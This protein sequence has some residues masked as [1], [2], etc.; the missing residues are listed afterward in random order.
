MIVRSAILFCL[1]T[2]LMPSP[3]PA[4]SSI[5]FDLPTSAAAIDVTPDDMTGGEKLVAIEF[6]LSLIADSLPS[7]QAEQLVVQ[8]SPLGGRAVIADY[9]PRTELGSAV[10]GEIEISRTKEVVDNLGL[11]LDASYGHLAH[12]NLGVDRGEKNI[13]ATK[14][15]EVAPL[16]IVAASGTT[17]R[18]RGVYFKL[19][20]D[21]RQVLEG[22][23]TF[24]VVLRV[25]ASW[26]GELM[27]VRVEAESL[28][29]GFSALA[30]MAPKSRQVG[31]ARFL[32]ATFLTGDRQVHA[33]AKHVGDA[34]LAMRESATRSLQGRSTSPLSHVAFRFDIGMSSGG[35]DLQRVT[36]TIERVLFAS[37][38]PYV[39]PQV[40]QLP[41]NVR[42]AILDYLDVRE[43]Y[44]RAVLQH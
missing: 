33:L 2:F 29:K 8:I 40:A 12:G 3:A 19:R 39:D 25:P 43:S 9:A 5:H 22:D 37:V 7:T 42:V 38:D 32:V 23:K 30:G 26:R 35:N 11:S 36:A 10:A 28:A 15:H 44:Q 13:S 21:N 27:D 6:N 31:A 1:A 17:H 41:V 4:E 24:R 20:A 16:H 34:E 14:Y 18:G